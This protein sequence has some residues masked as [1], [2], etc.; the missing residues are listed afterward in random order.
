MSDWEAAPRKALKELF[1]NIKLFGC[2]FHFTQR[3]WYKTQKL[4]LTESFKDN[5]EVARYT[6]Q[7]M[8]IPFLPASL[9]HPTYTLLQFPATIIPTEAMKL[10]KLNKYFKKRWITHVN[11]E[12]LSI[13][14]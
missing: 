1:P 9:I 2:W 7:L 6:R 10:E 13:F 4:G 8:S 12:E 14:D 5:I 3:I 11:P